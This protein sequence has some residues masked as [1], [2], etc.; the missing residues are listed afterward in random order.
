M[1]KCNKLNE[2][3]YGNSAVINNNVEYNP[4]FNWD[5]VVVTHNFCNDKCLN[6]VNCEMRCSEHCG[7]TMREVQ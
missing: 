5:D 2:S 1:C 3:N 6:Y 4:D 7:N